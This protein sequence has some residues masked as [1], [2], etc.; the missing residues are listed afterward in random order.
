MK[1]GIEEIVTDFPEH[2][3]RPEDQAY[4]YDVVPPPLKDSYRLPK[5]MRRLKDPYAAEIMTEKVVRKL[6]ETTDIKPTDID[7]IIANN[8]GGSLVVPM[9]GCYIHHKFGFPMEVPAFE[10]FSGLCKLS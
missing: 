1:I 3:V 6:F 9:I 10:H 7:Y 5:E 4:L 2:I 8:C